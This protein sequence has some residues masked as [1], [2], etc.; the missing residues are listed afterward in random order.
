VAGG[1]STMR[2][3]L[4][5]LREHAPLPEG[6]AGR[7]VAAELIKIGFEVETVDTTGGDITGPLVIGRVLEFTEQ[8]QKNGKIIRWCRVD[9]GEHNNGS[10]AKDSGGD[11]TESRGIIC[12]A[13]NFAVGDLVVVALPG[14]TLPGGFEISARKTYGHMS[15]GMICSA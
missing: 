2:A 15:D 11:D 9:V 4:S 12:G 6:V 1:R 14:T 8:E 13:R 10:Y 3:P 5:W 7:D